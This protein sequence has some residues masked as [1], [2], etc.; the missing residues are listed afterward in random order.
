VGINIGIGEIL[1][2]RMAGFG[3]VPAGRVV[4]SIVFL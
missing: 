4:E 2:N 1:L 3:L